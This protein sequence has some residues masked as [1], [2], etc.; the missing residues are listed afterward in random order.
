MCVFS[1]VKNIVIWLLADIILWVM[2]FFG[3]HVQNK[4]IIELSVKS[5]RQMVYNCVC[6]CVCRTAEYVL[7][8]VENKVKQCTDNKYKFY[9]HLTVNYFVK[10]SAECCIAPLCKILFFY[11]SS[12]SPTLFR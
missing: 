12:F 3:N 1:Q 10:D 7:C 8:N 2:A 11:D 9:R 6:V 4:P 5:P